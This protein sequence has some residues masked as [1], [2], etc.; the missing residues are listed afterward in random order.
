MQDSIEKPSVVTKTT[1]RPAVLSRKLHETTVDRDPTVVRGNAAS[2][3]ELP[4]DLKNV[5]NDMSN[6]PFLALPQLYRVAKQAP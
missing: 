2:R 4:L 5:Q 6:R 1:D 3:I